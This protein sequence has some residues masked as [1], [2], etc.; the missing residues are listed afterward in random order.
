MA[1][2]GDF[3]SKIWLVETKTVEPS[4]QEVLF[5]KE[6]A[7]GFDHSQSYTRTD[8]VEKLEGAIR[9]EVKRR[10]ELSRK[11]ASMVH[12]AFADVL[13]EILDE[14]GVGER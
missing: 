7:E 11:N 12:L 6:D 4:E 1:A 3:Q 2:L 10:R 8:L 14:H 9:D 5:T 13:Q